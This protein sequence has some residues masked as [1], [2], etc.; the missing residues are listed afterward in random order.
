MPKNIIMKH[1]GGPYGDEMSTYKFTV[2]GEEMTLEQFAE[3]V[4]EDEREWGEIRRGWMGEVLA[5]YKYGKINYRA[6]KN[7]I[8]AKEGS[9]SGGW[10]LMD[11]YVGVKG[12][13]QTLSL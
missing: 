5:S 11:Y 13:A 7:I 12:D 8:L 9:A 1:T 2:I 3:A 6:D 10:S 4:A